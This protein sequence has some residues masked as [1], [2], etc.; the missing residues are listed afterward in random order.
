VP[1]DT[2]DREPTAVATAVFTVPAE[3]VWGYRLDFAANL[4]DYNPDVSDV[5]QV[6]EAPA[7]AVGGA[8]GVGARYTLRLADPR[9]PGESQPV[10][11]WTVEAERPTLIAAGM[12]GANDAYEEFVVRPL[13]G[14]GC[15]ATLTLWLLL[16]EGLPDDV[17]AT[18][19]Q[20]SLDQISKEMR[21]M[22]RNL[23]GAAGA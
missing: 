5:R 8:H 2:P 21:L 22:K 7:D 19:A 9:R 12:A 6:E 1:T 10:E 17:V 11:M 14:G 3:D 18:A 4:A 23:E 16:P 15:E 13:D 20:G